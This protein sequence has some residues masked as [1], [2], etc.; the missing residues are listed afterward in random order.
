MYFYLI[1]LFFRFVCFFFIFP[2]SVK[3][4]TVFI[5]SFPKLIEHLYDLYLEIFIGQIAYLSSSPGV[6]SCSFM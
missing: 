4:L 6:L 5:H 3:L 2:N 1:I